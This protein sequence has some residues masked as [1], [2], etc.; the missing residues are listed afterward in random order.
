MLNSLKNKRGSVMII[1]MA[2]IMLA[3]FFT[4]LIVDFGLG[5]VARTQTQ[6]IA[7]SMVL[8]GASYGQEGYKSLTSNKNKA[9]IDSTKAVQKAN[10]IRNANIALLPSGIN[11]TS[12]AYNPTRNIDGKNMNSN[13]Q[14]YSGNFTV[15]LGGRLKTLFL[16]NRIPG[17]NNK[18]T[19]HISTSAQSRTKV[20]PK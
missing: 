17:L 18:K 16:G 10:Q 9:I 3:V 4:V 19:P 2:V 15:K 12:T 7:D 8:G 6:I 20:T 13:E 14:Y 5:Y 11:I 1:G